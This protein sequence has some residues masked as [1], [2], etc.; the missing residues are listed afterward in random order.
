MRASLLAL[1][2]SVAAPA[3]AD[4]WDLCANRPGLASDGCV[5]P[6]GAVQ[7]EASIAEWALDRRDGVRTTELSIAPMMLRAGLAGALEVRLAWTPHVRIVERFG[8][9]RSTSSGAGDLVLGAKLRLTGDDSPVRLAFEPSL[10]LPT[11]GKAVSQGSWS[12]ALAL[13]FDTALGAILSL[14]VSP[15][16]ALVPDS[17]GHGRHAAASLAASL[18]ASLTERWS[19]AFDLAHEEDFDPETPGRA[20]IAGLST[21][22]MASRRLQLDA[23]FQAGLGGDAPDVALLGGFSYRF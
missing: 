3:G 18:G 21:A 20:T 15:Q 19:A 12:A 10:V 2:L 7:L 17:D 6:A 1:L 16:V 13:P 8:G 22:F 11:G 9:G 4:E 5:L 14:A 23:E